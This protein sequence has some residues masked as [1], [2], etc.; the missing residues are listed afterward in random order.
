MAVNVAG[1]KLDYVD[2]LRGIAIIM[3]VVVHTSLSIEGLNKSVAAILFYFRTGVQL[4]FILSAFT[5]S[6]S[7][8]KRHDG[9]IRFYIRR[10]FRIAPL[11]YLAIPVYYLVTHLVA[12]P[13]KTTME[14]YSDFTPL[15]VL[16][17]FLF[18][19]GVVQSANNSIVP[20]GWSI[21]TEMLFYLIFPL[22]FKLYSKAENRKIYFIIPLAGLACAILYSLVC[23]YVIKV[24]LSTYKGFCFYNIL[25]Q[26]PVFLLGVSVFFLKIN[27]K[28]RYSILGLLALFPLSFVITVVL[29]RDIALQTFVVGL[30][31]VFLFCLFKNTPKLNV[32]IL[33]RIGQLSFSIYIFHFIFAWPI[34]AYLDRTMHINPYLSLVVCIAVTLSLSFVV[35]GL[36]ERYIENPGIKLGRYIAK[37][38]NWRQGA[39][40]GTIS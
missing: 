28:T 13:V 14:T 21:G 2:S 10:F 36:S 23:L 19:H 6:L 31:F 12:W 35:A 40:A 7:I 4:F 20:G 17:N 3:V 37:R 26:L 22:I 25:N 38:V 11:Y 39:N 15:N 29:K 24:N 30:S 34:S 1:P 9:N 5:L 27:M 16:A 8:T 32:Y 33:S 18:I